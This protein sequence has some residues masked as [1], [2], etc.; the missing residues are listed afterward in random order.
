MG[1]QDLCDGTRYLKDGR[2]LPPW[3]GEIPFPLCGSEG[4]QVY[5][6]WWQ[7]VGGPHF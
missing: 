2:K 6:L 4:G 5:L 7:E 3:I 1:G